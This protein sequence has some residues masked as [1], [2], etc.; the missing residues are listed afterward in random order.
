ML[1]Q[2]IKRLAFKP[3][4]TKTRGRVAASLLSSVSAD[5]DIA[6]LEET[7]GFVDDRLVQIEDRIRQ[8]KHSGRRVSSRRTAP[9]QTFVMDANAPWL[10]ATVA[11][12]EAPSMISDEEAQYYEYIG[13][14]YEGRGAAIELGPWLGRST[15]HI[16]RGLR[17]SSHFRSKKLYVFDDFVWRA[18][19]MDRHVPEHL[20]LPNHADFRPRFESFVRP[21]QSDLVVSVGRISDALNKDTKL[22][23]YAGNEHLPRIAWDGQPIEIMY[24]DCGRTAHVNEGWFEVFSS[25]FVPDLTLLL[26]QDWRTHRERPR[27]PYNQTLQFTVNHPELELIHEVSQGSLA[28]FL[29]RTAPIP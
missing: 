5:G 10:A 2:W 12:V 15:H 26:M 22:G 27:R 4:S 23:D 29:C 6:E 24:I 25:S 7:V 1:K 19:W 9:L 18:S 28:T 11:P 13:A 20:K 17:K 21:I 16:V 14:L 3:L 8:L